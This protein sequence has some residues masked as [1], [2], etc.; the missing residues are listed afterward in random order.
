MRC[1]RLQR[2][3]VFRQA[4]PIIIAN[5]SV[6]LLG[7]VDTAVIGQSGDAVGLGALAISN[8]I[9]NF[10][11][12]AFGFFR[13][14]TTGFVA[15]AHGAND[16]VEAQAAFVRSLALAFIFGCALVV[17]QPVISYSVFSLLR[18]SDEVEA[19]ARQYFSIR[20]WGAPATLALYGVMGVCI[21]CGR[22]KLLLL[23]QLGMNMA[24]I[25]LDIVF[26][27]WLDLGIR[28][29]A[30]GTLVAEWS[31]LVIASLVVFR[32]IFRVRFLSIVFLSS[33]YFNR[34][35]LLVFF[36]VNRDLFIRTLFLLAAFAW[37]TNASAQYGDVVL[38]GNHILLL[39]ISF[40]AFFLDGFAF[41]AEERVGSAIGKRD[42]QEALQS[43]YLTSE[44]AVLTALALGLCAFLFGGYGL[45]LLTDNLAVQAQ[46]QQF[47]HWA[48]LYI[49]V[50]VAAFQLD[51]VFIGATLSKPMRNASILSFIMFVSCS[52]L[53]SHRYGPDGLWAGF[54]IFVV[55]R[56]VC[57]S[58]YLPQLKARFW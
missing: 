55:S 27:S 6:P 51:G 8:L 29:I 21:G 28:G 41:V 7:L 49:V 40:S 52:T 37:F 1:S 35:S 11:Y 48:V 44:L 53:F 20:I 16:M 50:S 18:A 17:L 39:L 43:I 9:F 56:S 33:A 25:V 38:A 2:F 14:S 4:W 45:W 32:S 23:V 10:I 57:L 46:A 26:A 24:N 19:L 22:T 36:G 54:V 5:A 12:W 42:W 31:T 34:R 13:M 58:Y 3:H 15:Q 30:V 47:L